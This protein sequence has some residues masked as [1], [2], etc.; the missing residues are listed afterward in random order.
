MYM[1]VF[2]H[3]QG[4]GTAPIQYLIRTDVYGRDGNPPRV[5]RG[6]P[7]RSR[8]LIDSLETVWR[9]ISGVLSWHPDDTVTPEQEQAVMEDF[10]RLAFAGLEPDQYNILWVRHTHANHHELH[11]VIPRVELSTGKAF[12]PCPP[13]WQKQFDVF[14]DLHNQREHWA[15]PDDPQHARLFTPDH[16]DVQVAR[17]ARW[18]KSSPKSVRNEAKQAIHAYV[19][20]LIEHGRIQ[21]RQGVME[22]LQEV[23]LNV[24]R[25]GK[26]YITVEDPQSGERLRLKGSMYAEQFAVIDG[27]H[28]SQDRGGMSQGGDHYARTV[29]DLEQELARVIAKR[30][31]YNR[32][33]YQR[34][35]SELGK[36]PQL[37]NGLDTPNLCV[38]MPT[39]FPNSLLCPHGSGT[40][41]LGT[42]NH[43]SEQSRESAR[44]DCGPEQ[45]EEY[46]RP[47]SYESLE[48]VQGTRTTAT[49][50]RGL[51]FGADGMDAEKRG[52]DGRTRSMA[53]GT[54]VA[55]DRARAHFTRNGG[56]AGGDAQHDAERTRASLNQLAR[57]CGHVAKGSCSPEHRP[58]SLE[59]T[60]ATF[61]QYIRK[62]TAFVVSL[63]RGA[64]Q[65]VGRG[66]R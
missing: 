31:T 26:N 18:N 65:K 39:G 15:R 28:Q 7:E 41:K 19:K 55:H 9:Y 27:D 62:L 23:N 60:L 32:G 44:G 37:G 48:Y 12:N 51:S 63:E 57:R 20:S 47:Q 50:R 24:V 3:G 52:D 16:V 29:G 54:G 14:R 40:R 58:R 35:V 53:D 5:V 64:R 59:R 21:N 66:R 8:A 13:H 25:A 10:E 4:N 30:A 38:D 6:D 49:K 56:K 22:A 11:F 34:S 42:S 36:E 43:G 17:L 61:E 45:P 2:P 33:R 1:K 46:P